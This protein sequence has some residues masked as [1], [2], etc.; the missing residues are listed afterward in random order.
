[1]S[2]VPAIGKWVSLAVLILVASFAVGGVYQSAAVPRRFGWRQYFFN[3]FAGGILCVSE[4]NLPKL[5]L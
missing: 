3:R 2:I 1:M 5:S 4:Q